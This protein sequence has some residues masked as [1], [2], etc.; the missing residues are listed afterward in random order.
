[1]NLIEHAN[2]TLVPPNYNITPKDSDICCGVSGIIPPDQ[3]N[4]MLKKKHFGYYTPI[5]FRGYN[6]GKRLLE[7]FP[8]WS[9]DSF[10]YSSSLLALTQ[11]RAFNLNT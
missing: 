3:Y 5:D 1:M 11:C 10:T 6:T 2:G 8:F 4:E 7:G 9:S